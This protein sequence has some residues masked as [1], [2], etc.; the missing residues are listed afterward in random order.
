M[1]PFVPEALPPAEV[2]WIRVIPL[3]G[4]ANR[5]IAGYAASLDALPNPDLLLSPLTTNEAV[6][7]SKIEGTQATLG[8]V[9]KY[10]VGEE[11]THQGCRDDIDEILNYRK[12]LRTAEA[13]LE[14]RPFSLCSVH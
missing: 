7:S 6:L 10:E 12:T 4:L 9:L 1:K 14:R 3:I 13:E 8:D 2:D 11:P 5:S